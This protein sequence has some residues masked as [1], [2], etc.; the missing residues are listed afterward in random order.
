[1]ASATAAELVMPKKGAYIPKSYHINDLPDPGFVYAEATQLFPTSP[2]QRALHYSRHATYRNMALGRDPAMAPIDLIGRHGE[3]KTAITKDYVLKCAGISPSIDGPESVA[4]TLAN[5]YTRIDAGGL[6]DLADIT[7][8]KYIDKDSKTTKLA[9]SAMLGD[10]D[11]AWR[12]VLIDDWTR[13]LRHI[14]QGLMQIINTGRHSDYWIGAGS[15]IVCT[16]N[17][18]GDDYD[19][20]GIDAAQFSRTIPIVYNANEKTFFE[21]LEAQKI[22]P[23]MINFW[24]KHKEL[25]KIP[26]VKIEP[27]KEAASSRFRML[28][29]EIYEYA[30]YDQAVLNDIANSMFGPQ[31]LAMMMAD[32]RAQ[33]PIA[34]HEILSNWGP[35]LEKK[36]EEYCKGH[37][38]VLAVT[39]QRM[40]YYLNDK[41]TKVGNDELA[42]LVRF[43]AMLPKDSA[44]MLSKLLID[45]G[46][47]RA[48]FYATRIAAL[49]KQF[50]D[51]QNIVKQVIALRGSINQKLKQAGI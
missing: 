39:A 17:P 40:A 2:H 18:E 49:S 10:G 22:D 26:Q 7:G 51:D 8:L 3:G 34:P 1:M 48:D 13:A 30:K 4:L 9:R 50:P 33:Q 28:F 44:F 21:Q 41:D 14:K 24:T 15:F 32:R 11:S 16:R 43:S 35:H 36:V 20:D 25:C 46:Q 27:V 23:E 31:F 6:V 12:L 42:N 29:S 38:D 37:Q 19:V 5:H 47:P 45:D